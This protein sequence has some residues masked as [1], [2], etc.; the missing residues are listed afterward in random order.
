MLGRTPTGRPSPAA[1]VGAAGNFGYIFNGAPSPTRGRGTPLAEKQF[2]MTP[3]AEPTTSQELLAALQQTDRRVLLVS[4]RV[5]QRIIRF[6]R[7]L[8]TLDV[9][10]PHAAVYAIERERLIDFTARYEYQLQLP[11]DLPETVIL[12]P[13]NDES[14]LITKPAS[15]LL[16]TFWRKLFHI[17]L[18]LEARR[19]AVRDRVEPDWLL[20]RL[21]AIGAIPFAEARTV[22]ASEEQLLP[23]TN[24]LSEYIEFAA[25]FLELWYFAP[26][27]LGAFFPGIG[28]LDAVTRLLAEDFDHARLFEATRPPGAGDASG[29]G[30]RRGAIHR[31]FGKHAAHAGDEMRG[32]RQVN[33]LKPSEGSIR[34]AASPSNELGGGVGSPPNL[35][36]HRRL[37][38]RAR[39]ADGSGHY[40]KAAILLHKAARLA[41]VAERT[42]TVTWANQA[43]EQFAQHLGE[44][45]GLNDLQVAAL[46]QSLAEF[47][48][49]ADRGYRRLESRL[50]YDLQKVCTERQRGVYAVDAWRWIS[51]RTRTP[52]RRP[53]PLLRASLVRRHLN[54]ALRKLRRLSSTIGDDGDQLAEILSESVDQAGRD[55][56]AELRPAIREVFVA[57]GC[58]PNSLVESTAFAKIIEELLDHIVEHGR[59]SMGHLR[60]A[61]SQSNIK[62]PDLRQIRELLT[63]D[64]LLR[65]D[66]RLASILDGVYHRGPVYLRLA[67]RLSSLAFGTQF[68]RILSRY[69]ALPFGGAYLVLESYRHLVHFLFPQSDEGAVDSHLVGKDP[70]IA[71][72]TPEQVLPDITAASFVVIMGIFLMLLIENRRFRKWFFDGL[73]RVGHGLLYLVRDVPQLLLRLHWV[74]RIQESPIYIGAINYVI[75]PL[76][77]TGTVL[78]LY[79]RTLRWIQQRRIASAEQIESV[80]SPVPFDSFEVRFLILFLILNLFLNSP[81]G[82]YTDALVADNLRRGWRDLRLKVFAVAFRFIVDSFHWLLEI[83]EQIIYTV[84]SALRFRGGESWLT[85]SIKAVVGFF[86]SI[87]SYVIRI[88]I[89][90]LIE[91]QINPIKHFPVVTVS[92]KMILPFSIEL[93]QYLAAPLTPLLGAAL[94]NTVAV[95]TVFLLPGVFG[96]LAWELKENWRLYAANRRQQ[97][98]TIPIGS[99]GETMLRLLRPG[100]HSGTLPKGFARLR[101]AWHKVEAGGGNEAVRRANQRLH[102]V[103]HAVQIFV[104]REWIALLAALP[105]WKTA[106][107]Q[108][109]AVRLAT[110]EIAIDVTRAQVSDAPLQFSFVDA[111]GW[112][113]A[114]IDALG[115]AES[116]EER[117][118]AQLLAA[119]RGIYRYSGV[120]LV[121]SDLLQGLGMS[122]EPFWFDF[123]RDGVVIWSSARADSNVQYKL[124]DSGATAQLAP[125]PKFV[126]EPRH[127][128]LALIVFAETVDS[129]EFWTSTWEQ[130]AAPDPGAAAARS[131][132]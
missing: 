1:L 59:L 93:T 24:Y 127:E 125:P 33:P 111:G 80:A 98:G 57:E 102:H 126:T 8:S 45:L 54:S 94:G 83:T 82:R 71:P 88:Y 21:V 2:S 116:L 73:S 115:W 36:L 28:D 50:L 5:L 113:I 118:R 70:A 85:V 92:H 130:L 99:H 90:L 72:E 47:I 4:H 6:D 12:L 105:E 120:E 132:G 62:L 43:T 58:Q 68:G 53:L 11:R 39:R 119:F 124:R 131:A 122:R 129:W 40:A 16:R 9:R 95:T 19:L 103:Q 79:D 100:F 15:E 61:I 84:D 112:L 60:D 14:E 56:R 106:D 75:K 51:S 55:L 109:A 108:V 48:S 87:V 66:R 22:L 34:Q 29:P 25:Q 114:R 121:W 63:G 20:R 107:L 117:Q 46:R 38:A 31:Q 32:G 86:W 41:P 7:R 89:T 91:P 3:T 69:V 13:Q 30:R 35:G 27:E 10:V 97:L 26:E 101:K 17:H 104:E 67:H 76:L 110:N 96:F 18:H 49:R 128:D 78:L 37:V 23:P 52:L 77:I 64:Q 42:E 65:I 74:R 81:M 44:V 123:N